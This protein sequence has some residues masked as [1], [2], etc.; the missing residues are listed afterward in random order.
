MTK[1]GRAIENQPTTLV[2]TTA[3]ARKIAKLRA[4]PGV[5][6]ASART[7]TAMIE[8]DRRYVENLAAIRKAA[9]LT[10]IDL[11]RQMG[12]P[13]SEVSRIERQ[14]DMLLSTFTGY[15]SAAGE[16]PR[17]VVTINGQDVELELKV[18]DKSQLA[19]Q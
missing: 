5:A 14:T 3:A 15:L 18:I 8:D 11:A 13:Q 10:Q 17:V 1:R 12:V 7:Y 2:G 19:A 4:I 16:N 6:E 9:A